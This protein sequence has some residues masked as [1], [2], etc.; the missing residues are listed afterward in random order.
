MK[1]ILD[2]VRHLVANICNKL[3]FLKTMCFVNQTICAN[4]L[5]AQSFGENDDDVF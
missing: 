1:D 5:F 4:Y 3:N 2:L